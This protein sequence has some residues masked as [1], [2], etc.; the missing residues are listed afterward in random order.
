MITEYNVNRT[1]LIINVTKSIVLGRFNG[2]GR[3]TIET[4]FEN[5]KDLW[6]NDYIILAKEI[7]VI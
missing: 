1:Y 4:A 2:S 3:K 5:A 6:K 7:K